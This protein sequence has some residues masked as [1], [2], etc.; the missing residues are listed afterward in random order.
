VTPTLGRI[1]F[2]RSPAFIG[3]CPAIVVGVDRA[4]GLINVRVF[5]NDHQAP[6]FIQGVMQQQ[7]SSQRWGWRWPPRDVIAPPDGVAPPA[8]SAEEQLARV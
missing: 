5:T 6:M 8:Q 3:E 4:D 1:V 2:V 7:E